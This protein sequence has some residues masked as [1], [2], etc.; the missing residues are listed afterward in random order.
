M[1]IRLL[2]LQPMNRLSVLKQGLQLLALIILLV[3]NPAWAE[4]RQVTMVSDPWPPYVVGDQGA[5]AHSGIAYTIHKEIF[6]HIDGV[7]VT[8]PLIP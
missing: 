5:H 2:F 4:T 8:F 1:R 6:S 3:G 7:S